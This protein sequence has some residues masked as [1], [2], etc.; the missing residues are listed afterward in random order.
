[1]RIRALQEPFHLLLLSPRCGKETVVGQVVKIAEIKKCA[2][3]DVLEVT[4]EQPSQRLCIGGQRYRDGSER[5][6]ARRADLA[7]AGGG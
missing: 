1:M 3:L 6:P 2:Q 4:D 7:L 5:I